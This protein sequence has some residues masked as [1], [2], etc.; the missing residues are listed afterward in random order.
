MP[1][2]HLATFIFALLAAFA[3]IACSGQSPVAP[4][5]TS[6]GAQYVTT[7]AKPVDG[8][9]V[10]SFE[11][12]IS[13]LGVVLVAHVDDASGNPATS[14]TAIF[15][16]C[17]L[18]GVPAPSTECDNGLGGWVFVGRSGIL[19]SGPRVGDALLTY[20]LAP[21]SGTTIGFRFW[22]NGAGNG[23]ARGPSPSEDHTF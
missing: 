19:P 20:D 21:S 22:Y 4:G 6:D 13:G 15:Q 2:R 5:A 11:P 10:L 8:T 18:Q 14:G 12:T 16:Y 1:H 23:I 3:F 9:Y 7:L 17:S